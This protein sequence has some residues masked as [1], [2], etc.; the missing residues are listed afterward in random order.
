MALAMLG[1]DYF[2]AVLILDKAEEI[3]GLEAA[4]SSGVYPPWMDPDT[5]PAQLQKC[6]RVLKVF[7][8]LDS[9]TAGV[10]L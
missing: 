5:A 8:A 1:D 4:I 9:A 7:R 3:A 10:G 2:Y 6:R